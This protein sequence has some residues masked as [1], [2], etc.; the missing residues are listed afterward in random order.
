[1]MRPPAPDLRR[2][3]EPPCARSGRPHGGGNP[4][5]TST[6][7][8][9]AGAL[10]ARPAGVDGGRRLWQVRQPAIFPRAI[11]ERAPAC[12]GCGKNIQRMQVRACDDPAYLRVRWVDLLPDELA[13]LRKLNTTLLAIEQRYQA[14]AAQINPALEARTARIKERGQGRFHEVTF[15]TMAAPFHNVGYSGNLW[16]ARCICATYCATAPSGA[17]W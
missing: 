2:G 3:T 8:R 11:R 16:T 9:L 14:E 13:P 10:P 5:G 12:R 6:P 17:T 7:G 4:G 1:M 15:G